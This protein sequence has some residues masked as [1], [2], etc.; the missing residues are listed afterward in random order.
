MIKCLDI[1]ELSGGKT[2]RV[3]NKSINN[4]EGEDIAR[5]TTVEITSEPPC[6]HSNKQKS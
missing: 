4:I 6:L 2:Q 5:Q 1:A 3:L